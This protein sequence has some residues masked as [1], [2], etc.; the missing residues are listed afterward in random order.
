MNFQSVPGPDLWAEMRT[1]SSDEVAV[2]VTVTAAATFAP[3]PV[4]ARDARR[5]LRAF[6]DE[7]DPRGELAPLTWPSEWPSRTHGFLY[8]GQS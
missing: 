1:K 2:A 5:F 7:H 8:L 4:S 6:L 3:L